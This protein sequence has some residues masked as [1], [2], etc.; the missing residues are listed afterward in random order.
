MEQGLSNSEKIGEALRLLEEAAK[1]KKEEL[2]NLAANKF[3]N[4]KAALGATEQTVAAA[5]SDAGK[6][7]AEAARQAAEVGAEKAKVVA[8]DVNKQVHENPWPYI[9]G[10]AVVG[11]LFGYILGRNK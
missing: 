1:G 11:V 6:R 3:Q 8:A 5:V 9:G 7:A 4:L 2:R 10:A